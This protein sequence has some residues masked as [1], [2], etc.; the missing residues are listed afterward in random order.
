M[1][2][3]KML[4]EA[5][6]KPYDIVI[7]TV[8]SVTRDRPGW[9]LTVKQ[10]QGVGTVHEGS[11]DHRIATSSLTM[12]VEA[13]T[14]TIQLLA[15]QRDAQITHAIVLTDSL[16]LQQKVGFW[17]ELPRLA[18]S[19]AQSSAAKNSVDLPPRACKSQWE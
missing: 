8:G 16:R 5:N 6:S 9:G 17:N 11:G 4:V 10:G 1:Q 12:K 19:H 2:K 15:S 3:H 7:Y 13:V 14:H 18:H